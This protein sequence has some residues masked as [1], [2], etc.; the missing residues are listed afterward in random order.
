MVP[1][2]EQENK[3]SLLYQLRMREIMTYLKGVLKLDCEG[4]QCKD[5]LIDCI[6]CDVLQEH[7]QFL[8]KVV[9]EKVNAAAE[10]LICELV[11]WKWICVEEHP[12]EWC[13]AQ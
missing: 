1:S 11:V 9:Q 8:C 4:G 7:I 2:E 12:F 5:C 10:K 13:M 3:Q 6:V